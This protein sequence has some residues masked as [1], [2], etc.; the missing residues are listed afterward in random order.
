[1]ANTGTFLYQE[2]NNYQSYFLNFFEKLDFYEVLKVLPENQLIDIKKVFIETGRGQFYEAYDEKEI[3][4]PRTVL[5]LKNKLRSLSNEPFIQELDF[6]LENKIFFH[7]FEDYDIELKFQ[8]EENEIIIKN[9]LHLLVKDEGKIDKLIMEAKKNSG[10]YIEVCF[11][12]E[13][14]KIHDDFDSYL[15]SQNN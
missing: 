10:K 3:D 12:G 14:K 2:K 8:N 4:N 1:M 9:I 11:N 15:L 5:E 13:I 6:W 7:V